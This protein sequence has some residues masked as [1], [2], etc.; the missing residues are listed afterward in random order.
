[1]VKLLQHPSSGG[2]GISLLLSTRPYYTDAQSIQAMSEGL[3]LTIPLPSPS[4]LPPTRVFQ[5]YSSPPSRLLYSWPPP[6]PPGDPGQLDGSYNAEEYIEL[7][8]GV[9]MDPSVLPHTPGEVRT[10]C[11]TRFGAKHSMTSEGVYRLVESVFVPYGDIVFACFQTT[12]V[13]ELS[14]R[15]GTGLGEH[16]H[17]L[18]QHQSGVGMGM[19]QQYEQAQKGQMAPAGMGMRPGTGTGVGLARDRSRTPTI[20]TTPGYRP[21]ESPLRTPKG[22][23]MYPPPLTSAP[24][25]TGHSS[26]SN[27]SPSHLSSTYD[28]Q[29]RIRHDGA[30]VDPYGQAVG[31]RREGEDPE[32]PR[33][34]HSTYSTDNT[35]PY[36]APP[37]PLHPASKAQADRTLQPPLTGAPHP[38][39]DAPNGEAFTRSYPLLSL[40]PPNG[41]AVSALSSGPIS[42]P[43]HQPRHPLPV[44]LVLQPPHPQANGH[45]HSHSLSHPP[46][47]HLLLPMHPPPMDDSPPHHGYSGS[48]HGI[49]H[50]GAHAHGHGHGPGHGASTR[51]LIRPPDGIECCVMCGTRESPEWR[52]NESGI[53][54]LCNAYV[55]IVQGLWRDQEWDRDVRSGK[56]WSLVSAEVET[57]SK[58]RAQVCKQC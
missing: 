9:N 53:K 20:I 39:A 34:P 21:S 18:H 47:P 24:L 52:R 30:H 36:A 15:S 35:H 23:G 41:M 7:L 58:W 33:Y 3:S 32:H 40:P 12:K 1:M 19:G 17:G 31:D 5:L 16:A 43:H 46:P 51:P 42:D 55:I 38:L 26:S 27:A 48:A 45:S 50:S 4:R 49:G 2:R 6:R 56:I 44:P 28:E 13:F 57:G 29:P 37:P 25:L 14:P 11:S 54:D 22:Q 10:T 8:S